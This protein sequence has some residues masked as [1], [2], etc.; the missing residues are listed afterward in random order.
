M[1]EVRVDEHG[2]VWISGMKI[3]RLTPW[4]SIEFYDRDKRRAEVRGSNFI[5]ANPAHLCQIFSEISH[6]STTTPCTTAETD[7]TT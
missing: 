7:R 5:Y 4:G 3:C 6:E 2:Y 1:D